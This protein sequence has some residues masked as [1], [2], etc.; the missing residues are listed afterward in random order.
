[1]GGHDIGKS[2]VKRIGKP[3]PEV[4]EL[5]LGKDSINPSDAIMVG[6]ALETDIIGGT[7]FQCST[8]WVINDGIHK[9][10]I[11]ELMVENDHSFEEAVEL[12]LK[13]FNDKK[14]FVDK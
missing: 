8:L 14:G 3:F 2:L 1:M 9:G 12:V 10:S 5:A 13:T 6:D 7:N 4:Y 11:K